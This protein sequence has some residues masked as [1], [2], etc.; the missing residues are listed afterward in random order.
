MFS[1]L[2]KVALSIG[3]VYAQRVYF[4]LDTANSNKTNNSSYIR[5]RSRRR[6]YRR[7]RRRSRTCL[8]TI[9]NFY[10]VA[11]LKISAAV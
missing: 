7:S 9:A 6:R 3:S 5:S 2:F 11:Q 10:M 1:V 8:A 4:V